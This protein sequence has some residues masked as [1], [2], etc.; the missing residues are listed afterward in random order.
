MDNQIKNVVPKYVRRGKKTWVLITPILSSHYQEIL[1]VLITPILSSHYQE[2]LA[3][4]ITPILSG[5]YQ[6]IQA[7]EW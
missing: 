6:E 5:H 7:A 4:L 2:I 3:V 1:A